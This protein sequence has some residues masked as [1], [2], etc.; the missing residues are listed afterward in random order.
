[1]KNSNLNR[2]L[3]MVLALVLCAGM[4]PATAIPVAAESTASGAMATVS[5]DDFSAYEVGEDTFYQNSNY[6][7]FYEAYHNAVGSASYATYGIA[8][9]GN[10][11][12]L[13]LTSVNETPNYFH[14]GTMLTGQRAVTMDINFRRSDGASVPGLVINPLEGHTFPMGGVLVYIEA[15]G[16]VKFRGDLNSGVLEQVLV[17]GADGNPL[18]MEHNTWY[19]IKLTV[20]EGQMILKAWQKGQPEPADNA[21]TGVAVYKSYKLDES[22]MASQTQVRIMTRSRNRAGEAYTT[23]IDNLTLS[24]A[25]QVNL[26]DTIVGKNGA[27][28]EPQIVGAKLAKPV[29]TW[30]SSDP[31]VVT[32]DTDGR[33]TAVKN[34]KATV[35]ANLLDAGGTVLTSATCTVTVD[36]TGID[37]SALANNYNSGDTVQLKLTKSASNITWSTS[38]STVATVD[39]NGMVTCKTRGIA[40]I[41]ANWLYNSTANSDTVTIQVGESVKN[42]KLLVIGSIYDLDSTFY[43]KK[44]DMLYPDVNF[45]VAVLNGGDISVQSHARNAI[46]DAAAYALYTPDATGNL[47]KT[48]ENVRIAEMLAGEAWDVV[49]VGSHNFVAGY[50]TGYRTDMKYMLDYLRDKESSARLLWP[51]AWSYADGY[52]PYVTGTAVNMGYTDYLENSAWMY[53]AIIRCTN[54]FILGRTDW[55]DTAVPIGVA[56]Q[57]LR[58]T[59]GRDLTRDSDHLS[60]KTGRLTAG[61]TLF[62]SLCLELGYTPDLS[63][64]TAD[65][66]NFLTD[67]EAQ[68]PDTAY[69]ASD[70]AKIADAVKAA[71]ADMAD[72]E[73]T[74][75]DV[76]NHPKNTTTPGAITVDQVAPPSALRFPDL[77]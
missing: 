26:P 33:L 12:V 37:T 30:S 67:A 65:N 24:A 73:L 21:V 71:F 50:E 5:V 54:R 2:V 35:T 39:A 27:K 64:L 7:A 66:V 15:T 56:V 53:N 49:M 8:K 47:V 52:D 68:Y 18:R 48:R 45:D 62:N 20:S 41:T 9:D 55:F 28:L 3:S 13:S 51:V 14:T 76:P 6:A 59:L 46:A 25:V 69:K 1:M 40:K 31:S 74:E 17:N 38:D 61:L 22:V 44:L 36:T 29:Y 16:D 10:N 23:W 43:L 70:L 60:N 75:L 34:G 19:T 63:L 11:Q 77:K 42:L 58:A 4:V 32:V 57:N 72:K